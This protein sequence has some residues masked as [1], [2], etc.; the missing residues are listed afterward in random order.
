M[1]QIVAASKSEGRVERPLNVEGGEE[2]A[3]RVKKDGA[4]G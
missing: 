2:K 3:E 4:G 1:M